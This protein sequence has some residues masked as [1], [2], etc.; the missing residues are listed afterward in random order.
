[1]FALLATTLPESYQVNQLEHLTSEIVQRIAALEDPAYQ[2]LS[3]I[4]VICA[5]DKFRVALTS[6]KH[7]YKQLSPSDKISNTNFIIKT[8]TEVKRSTTRFSSLLQV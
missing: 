1:M 4:E 6:S 7:S 3:Q 2:H 8:L 5:S